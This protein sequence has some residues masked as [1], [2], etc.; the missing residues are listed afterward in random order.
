MRILDNSL[1]YVCNETLCGDNNTV[2]GDKNSIQGDNNKIYGNYCRVDGNNNEIYGKSC[3]MKGSNNRVVGTQ[4]MIEFVPILQPMSQDSYEPIEDDII[5][6]NIHISVPAAEAEVVCDE[7]HT[8][9]IICYTNQV[10]TTILNCGHT[11]LCISCSRKL[12]A[13]GMNRCPTCKQNI[14]KIIRIYL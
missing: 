7:N 1:V 11:N 14:H 12:I 8:P 6:S 10:R 4:S 3:I 5:P 13:S 9:C 2:H